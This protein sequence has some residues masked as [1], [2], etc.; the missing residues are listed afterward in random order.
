[1]LFILLF[2]SSSWCF[3]NGC[4]CVQRANGLGVIRLHIPWPILSRE[5]ELQKIKVPV[6]KVSSWA[7]GT[8]RCIWW[9]TVW[10]QRMLPVLQKCELR[11]RMGIAGMWDTIMTKISKPFQP[12]VPNVDTY[13]D[14]QTRTNFK[15]LKHAFI[16]DKLYLWVPAPPSWN[17]PACD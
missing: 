13:K 11:K 6:K 12:D 17:T 8:L 9:T 15:T 2:F 14:S 4:V 7:H 5:A 3:N 16:R 1:M 10:H